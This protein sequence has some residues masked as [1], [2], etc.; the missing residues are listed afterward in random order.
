VGGWP[1][2]LLGQ[3]RKSVAATAGS[4]FPSGTDVIGQVDHVRK[5]PKGDIG[6]LL[7]ITSFARESSEGGMAMPS[8]F[9]VLRLIDSGNLHSARPRFC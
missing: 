9:A 4:A 2:S 3:T 6:R 5:G 7:R 8:S 1:I